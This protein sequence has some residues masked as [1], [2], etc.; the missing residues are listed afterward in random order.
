MRV[1]ALNCRPT[2]VRPSEPLRTARKSAPSA[3]ETDRVELSGKAAAP[4]AV[5]DSLA[6]AAQAMLKQRVMECLLGG[7]ALPVRHV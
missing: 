3:G 4:A 7:V 6:G 5:W 1:T 2:G